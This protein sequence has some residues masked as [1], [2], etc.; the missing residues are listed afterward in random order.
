MQFLWGIRHRPPSKIDQVDVTWIITVRIIL[1]VTLGL[2][3]I[4][5]HAL[6]RCEPLSFILSML[7][8][9]NWKYVI[10][11]NEKFWLVWIAISALSLDCIWLAVGAD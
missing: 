2:L 4:A 8:A 3:S 1:A 9:R 10:L 7:L 6:G 5:V 11:A